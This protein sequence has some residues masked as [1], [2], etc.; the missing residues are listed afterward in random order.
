MSTEAERPLFPDAIDLARR[1]HLFC[2]EDDCECQIGVGFCHC[3]E[4]GLRCPTW[5]PA[6]TPMH[7]NT[8]ALEAAQEDEAVEETYFRLIIESPTFDIMDPRDREMFLLELAQ[9]CITW[10]QDRENY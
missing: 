7:N 5:P 3:E 8:T 1:G 4:Y 9:Q 10:V 2:H 6:F